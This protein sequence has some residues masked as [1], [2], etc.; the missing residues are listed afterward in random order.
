[1][2]ASIS[3]KE[4]ETRKFPWGP[5]LGALTV[6]CPRTLILLPRPCGRINCRHLMA[7]FWS[8]KFMNGF[9][10]CLFTSLRY[11]QSKLLHFF[12]VW[13]P[14]SCWTTK[15]CSPSPALAKFSIRLIFCGTASCRGYRSVSQVCFELVFN[16]SAHERALLAFS[17]IL[18]YLCVRTVLGYAHAI[19]MA[20]VLHWNC[21]LPRPGRDTRLS[22]PPGCV[23]QRCLCCSPRG[24]WLW[25]GLPCCNSWV[26][27]IPR[28]TYLYECQKSKCKRLKSWRG[29]RSR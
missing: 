17:V 4:V 6:C 13:S 24:R 3:E 8:G 11:K 9:V 27:Q 29:R 28:H 5:K 10:C 7:S 19:I 21:R 20:L 14:R 1:M 16:K 15:V 26:L 23:R 25:P 2:I 12:L 22:D 18:S